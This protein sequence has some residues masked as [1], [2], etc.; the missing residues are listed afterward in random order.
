MTAPT[1]W[2]ACGCV[3]RDADS[4]EVCTVALW[5]N[6][7]SEA[8][9]RIVRAVNC[10]AE[11]LESLEVAVEWLHD[12]CRKVCKRERAACQD[13]ECRRYTDSM[14]AAIAKAKEGSR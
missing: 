14:M 5:C 13:E 9:A 8:A 12:Y 10:H 1:P 3:I 11:L 4:I 6:Q 2:E 7:P